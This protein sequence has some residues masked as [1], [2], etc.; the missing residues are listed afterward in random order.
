[1][2]L[3]TF[4]CS[5]TF[6]LPRCALRAHLFAFALFTGLSLVAGSAGAVDQGSV[7]ALG[8]LEPA[9]GV[10]QLSGPSRSGVIRE[11][12]VE[13]GERV[14]QGQ[15]VA[16]MDSY[17]L[18]T[19]QVD[20]LKAELKN[21]QLEMGRAS[22]LASKSAA[23]AAKRDTAELDVAI[24]NANLAAAEAELELSIVRA[25]VA[26]RVLEIHAGVGE[27]LGPEGILEL[28]RTDEMY[29]IAEVYE[30]DIGRVRKNQRAR[31]TSPAL[32]GP[33]EG[34]VEYIGLKVGKQDL[35]G[36]D[37]IAKTDARVI[38]VGIRLDNQKGAY[39]V[40][41]LTYLQVEVEILP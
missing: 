10:V 22:K 18:N 5:T 27:R 9:N 33:V 31:I 30:T 13:V 8:R 37:P 4:N 34:T 38:E 26:A 3:Q 32:S 2:H 1:M 24:A 29:A 35:I 39:D 41:N 17:A 12:L 11:L 36:T 6:H 23:S 7:V 20:R 15:K 25:P 21:A 16:I 19:A 28:G 14:E 40:S